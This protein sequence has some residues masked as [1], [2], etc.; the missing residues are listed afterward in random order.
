MSCCGRVEVVDAGAGLVDDHQRV[1]PDVALGVPLGLLLAADQGLELGEEA[2]DDPQVEGELEAEGR[3]PGLEQQLLHLAAD[4]FGGEV[5]EGDAAADAGGGVVGGD[6]E[7]G[8]ELQGA[9]DAQAVR[10]RRWRG[11]TTRSRRR[12]RSPRPP[13]GSMYSLSRGSQAMALM[14]KSR[15]RA[16]SSTGI[17]GSPVTTKP[18]WP[19]PCFDSVRGRGDVDPAHLVDGEALADGVDGADLAEQ[20]AEP[21]GLDAVDLEVDVLRLAADQAIPDPTAD[22]EGAAAGLLHAFGNRFRG[23]RLVH[24]AG[25]VAPADG[26]AAQ[27]RR[28]HNGEW[29]GRSWIAFDR[30]ATAVAA[31]SR[32]L[33]AS[34]TGR[35]S[36]SQPA[37]SRRPG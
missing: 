15:R 30:G 28:R 12:S 22:I 5:V 16:A 7:P 1:H 34:L 35:G 33:A 4:A 2:L 32:R 31:A 25:S 14:V 9:Q 27:S 10:R 29:E 8:R 37:R 13:K 6:L 17:Q 23:L 3:P 36:L 20:R 18:R 24:R 19:R 11:S 21:V 26:R